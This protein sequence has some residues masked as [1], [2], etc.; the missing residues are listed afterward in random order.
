MIFFEKIFYGKQE[1]LANLYK[2]F[3]RIQVQ[4]AFEFAATSLC[5][6]YI[7]NEEQIS[8]EL[9]FLIEEEF[10]EFIS[11]FSKELNTKIELS[12]ETCQS[13]ITISSLEKIKKLYLKEENEFT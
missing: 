13:M 8:N 6:R 10:E 11:Y 1:H 4:N 3:G 9:Y 12:V 7:L 5:K 2:E